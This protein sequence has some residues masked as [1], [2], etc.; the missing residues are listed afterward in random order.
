MTARTVLMRQR[1]EFE[2]WPVLSPYR[3]IFLAAV[4]KGLDALPRQYTLWERLCW[5]WFKLSGGGVR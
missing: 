1:H 4:D 2:V 5:F 3:A